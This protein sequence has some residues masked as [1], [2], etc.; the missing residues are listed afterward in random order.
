MVRVDLEDHLASDFRSEDFDSSDL[1]FIRPKGRVTRPE[2]AQGLM[3]F[4]R[5]A[6]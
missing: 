5:F 2:T 1:V 4:E 3:K 6:K